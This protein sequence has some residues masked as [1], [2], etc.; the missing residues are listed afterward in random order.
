MTSISTVLSRRHFLA[1]TGG[2]LA[3][4]SW[5][6]A[7]LRPASEN[8]HV[9]GEPVVE[10]IGAK[11]LADGGN[12]VDALIATALAGAITQPHQTGIGGYATHGMFAMDGGRRIAA[13]DANT[14]AP[15]AFTKDI[16]KPDAQGRVPDARNYHGWLSTGV[17]GVIAGL[18]LAL[19]EFGTMSFG[20]VLAPAIR[21]ARE[22]FQLPASLA[23]TMARMKASFEKDAGTARLYLPGG[24]APAA[25]SLFKNPQLADVLDTLAKANSIEPFYRGDIAQCIAEGFSKNGG[26]VTKEDLAAYRARWVEPLRLACGAH[27]IHTPPLACGGI[28][29]LQMLAILKALKWDTITDGRERLVL[30]VEAMRL[31]WRDR[32]TL[33]GDPDFGDVP[34]A[35]LL[36]EDYASECAET[37]RAAVKS[38]QIL[39]PGFKTSTQGGTLN[40]SASDKHGNI[41]TLTLTHGDGFGAHVT[42]DELGLTLGHGMSRFDPRPDH[43]NAP[44]PRKRPLHNMVPML[45]TKGSQPVVAIGGRGGRRIPNAMLEFL[46]QHVVRGR[47]F[48]ES[49]ASPRLHTEGGKL[50]EHQKAWPKPSIDALNKAGYSVKTGGSATLSGVALENG[51]WLAGM[52]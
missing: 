31:A 27:T 14:M 36:S 18:K 51:K 45:I 41:A 32:L 15:A 24:A 4:S 30:R 28:T 10:G 20:D 44:G 16:F 50:V 25:G 23:G 2:M 7:E 12:A 19:D 8:G 1:Q 22:G 46:T 39:E 5:V 21:L 33:L 47:P 29:V 6:R 26:L 38:G 40:F 3:A 11:I 17:P 13:L 34:Q 37:I 49:L 52:T 42:V 35:K 43:P 9:V 48:G